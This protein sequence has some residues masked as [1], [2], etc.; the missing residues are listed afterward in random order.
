MKS[1]LFITIFTLIFSISASASRPLQ[2]SKEKPLRLD[3]DMENIV[4]PKSVPTGY[5]YDWADGSLFRPVRKGFHIPGLRGKKRESVNVNT[6][7]EVPDSSW[8]TNR[9]GSRAMSI[10]EVVRGP[11]QGRGPA[12]G[13]LVVL[14]GKTVGV[15]PGFWVKDENGQIFILKF[16]PPKYPELASGAEIVAT[17]MFHAF[18]YNVAQNYI[19]RF[20]AE[21]LTIGEKAKFTKENGKKVKMTRAHLDSILAQVARQRDGRYRSL[22]SKL[23][24]GKPKGG[25]TFSGRRKDDAN[26]IIPHENRRDLRALRM[27]SA[28]TEHNDVR[29]GNTLD[30]FVEEENRKFVRHYLIDFGSTFGSDTSQPNVPE[31]GHE[32]RLDMAQAQK[33]LL[34]A[35]FHQPK[36]RSEKYD[37][38]F[39]PAI[40]RYSTKSFRP[41]KWKANFPLAAFSQMKDLDAFWAAKII[42]SFTPEQ[43]RAVV[44]T[45]EYTDPKDT[46][47]LTRQMIA[48]Q[49]II[50]RHY[51]KKRTGIGDFAVSSNGVGSAIEFEDYRLRFPVDEF[52]DRHFRYRLLTPGKKSKVIAA[53]F[54]ENTRFELDAAFVQTIA[55]MGNTEKDR[56][57][58]KLEISRPGGKSKATVYL[59][60]K[61]E[62][63][64]EIAGIVH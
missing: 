47:Y 18:G 55:R 32:H 44:E 30:M 60:A 40:G 59:W 29:V 6:W 25:F 5:L 41:N 31:V 54:F 1:I 33:V 12:Q 49:H 61:N 38:V 48:R 23:I 16:D 4:E 51:S 27:F 64:L 19:Y 63:N 7:D 21:N 57:I 20:R 43:I 26:D 46:E 14:R 39:S 10:D 37:P 58:A 13:K 24:K 8:F 62:R 50:V 45:A 34:T 53:G 36:W 9:I 35:G 42:A 28:W 22:A 52:V 2:F 17:K 3:F 56:G 11:N 15:T